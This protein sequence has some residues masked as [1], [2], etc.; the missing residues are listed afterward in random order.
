MSYKLVNPAGYTSSSSTEVNR[1]GS[2]GTYMCTAVL[3]NNEAHC[4]KYDGSNWNFV[5]TLTP[6]DSYGTENVDFG[7]GLV[8][9][10]NRMLISAYRQE[11]DPTL[12]N[13]NWGGV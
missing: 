1:I 10:D 4:F 5:E 2:D 9:R 13:E 7:K 12:S 3:E 11:G 8:M 6:N